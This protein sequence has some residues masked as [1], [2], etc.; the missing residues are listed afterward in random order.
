MNGGTSIESATGAYGAA[1]LAEWQ[2]TSLGTVAPTGKYI[3]QGKKIT[4]GTPVYAYGQIT[5][6]KDLT[7]ADND[8]ATTVQNFI[9]SGIGN[10]NE[11]WMTDRSF[12]KLREVTLGYS[13]PA[14]FFAKHK[15]IKA[16]TISLVGRNLLY[17]S[18]RKDIDLDQFAS[19]Y[20]DS[21]KSL[22]NGGTLQS[23]TARRFGFNVNLS[24]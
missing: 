3:A 14:K 12:A 24:F 4:N 2:T 23:T 22:G 8:V 16:A 19:G 7:L 1:R 5:N 18:K 13:F 9:S 21:D 6:L 10:V 20:N 17:F 15:L 11:Y